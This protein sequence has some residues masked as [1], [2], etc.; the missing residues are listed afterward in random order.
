MTHHGRIGQ[1][2]LGLCLSRSEEGKGRG[3]EDDVSVPA[4]LSSAFQSKADRP[5]DSY[6]VLPSSLAA[7][8]RDIELR[9]S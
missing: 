7:N 8:M 5:L 2:I 1:G 9:K 3:I 4:I 6:C